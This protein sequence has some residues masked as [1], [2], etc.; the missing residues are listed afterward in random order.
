MWQNKFIAIIGLWILV[1]VFIGFS[2]TLLKILLVLTAVVLFLTSLSL[3][4][5]AGPKEEFEELDRLLK[6]DGKSVSE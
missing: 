1:L 3:R 2:E 5:P 4:Y 6:E